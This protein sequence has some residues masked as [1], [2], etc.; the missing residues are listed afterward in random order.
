MD[1]C[2]ITAAGESNVVSVA[3]T[4]V[5]QALLSNPTKDSSGAPT[6]VTTVDS[7]TAGGTL[8]GVITGSATAPSCANIA[9]GLDHTGAAAVASSSIVSVAGTNTLSFSVP[10]M[11]DPCYVHFCQVTGGVESNTQSAFTN[12]GNNPPIAG[13]D[14]NF[15]QTAGIPLTINMGANDSDPDG[16]PLT[17][18]NLAFRNALGGTPTGT[19]DPNTGIA[20]INDNGAT[21]YETRCTVYDSQGAS[22]RP[23]WSQITVV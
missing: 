6:I 15:T 14:G 12:T 3:A 10:N 18:G 13:N 17:W 1:F 9:A 11:P 4:P 19:L 5:S 7:D 21:Y 23:G 20:V 8:Y 22:D 2:Q 16:D